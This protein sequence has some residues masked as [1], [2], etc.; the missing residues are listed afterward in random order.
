ML[1]A[2]GL[3]EKNPIWVGRLHF[4]VPETAKYYRK[5]NSTDTEAAMK[6]PEMLLTSQKALKLISLICE[7]KPAVV[8]VDQVGNAEISLSAKLK[9]PLMAPT[10]EGYIHHLHRSNVHQ[11]LLDAGLPVPPALKFGTEV[12]PHDFGKAALNLIKQHMSMSSWQVFND[13][14]KVR[15]IDLFQQG[16][17]IGLIDPGEQI[18]FLRNKDIDKTSEEGRK[19]VAKLRKHILTRLEPQSLQ[20]MISSKTLLDSI[21]VEG[22]PCQLGN[23][24]MRVIE[25]SMSV[26]PKGGFDLLGTFEQVK[27]KYYAF[28]T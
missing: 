26:N 17:N 3:P 4:I 14:V 20:N 1:K 21:I 8:F 13:R 15:D 2:N 18:E 27:S 24:K 5:P 22:L 25:F 10:V 9:L 12:E 23:P 11:F 19:K 6:L 28:L 7:K 16:A